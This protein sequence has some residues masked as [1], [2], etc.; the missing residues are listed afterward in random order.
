MGLMAAGELNS[1]LLDTRRAP[2]PNPGIPQLEAHLMSLTASGGHRDVDLWAKELRGSREDS[3]E[4]E[5]GPERALR[6]WGPRLVLTS[7]V[8]CF[9][10]SS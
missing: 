8:R 10:T 4:A 5:C 2:Q 6:G 9:S 1:T 7:T 3:A